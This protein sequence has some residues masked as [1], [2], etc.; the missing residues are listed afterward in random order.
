MR[1]LARFVGLIAGVFFFST[2]VLAQGVWPGGPGATTPLVPGQMFIGVGGQVEWYHLPKFDSPWRT[3]DAFGNDVYRPSF[4]PDPTVY[5]PG[6]L[7][8]YV[9]PEGTFPRW[10]GEKVRVSFGGQTW[11]GLFSQRADRINPNL[12]GTPDGY[13][14]AAPIDGSPGTQYNFFYMNL[15]AAGIKVRA[16]GFELS[17]RLTADHDVARN[18]KLSPF[19]AL[20]GGRARDTYKFGARLTDAISGIDQNDIGVYTL[21]ERLTSN[22]VGMMFGTG[23]SVQVHRR[24]LLHLSGQAGFIFVWTHMSGADCFSGDNSANAVLGQT[25][26][27]TPAGSGSYQTTTSDNRSTV[28]FRG[29]V[30]GGVSLDLDFAIVSLS[31]FMTYDTA[32]PGVRNPVV[33][34]AITN[35]GDNNQ[36]TTG[37]ARIFFDDAVNYGALLLVRVPLN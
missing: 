29:G 2:Q 20:V 36:P 7:F 25:C 17:L 27:N 18:V 10:V 22:R 26:Y 11:N 14:S 13:V 19:V 24:V 23:V 16:T 31:G 34:T 3:A 9:F 37:R 15:R 21:D 8:G 32:V 1:M 12:V 35:T 4:D 28:G 30:N 6:G 5:G 33:T